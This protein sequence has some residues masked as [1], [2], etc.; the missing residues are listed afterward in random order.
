MS[1]FADIICPEN[2][3]LFKSLSLFRY[4]VARQTVELA[5]DVCDQLR[6]V[7][8]DYEVFSLAFDEKYG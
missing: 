3:P 7:A 1:Q 2:A 4:T 5:D 6:E 8:K